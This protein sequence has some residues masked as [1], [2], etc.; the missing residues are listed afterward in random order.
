MELGVSVVGGHTEF[1][2][3]VEHPIVA[4]TMIGVIDSER[5]FSVKNAEV[6]DLIV[7]TKAAGIEAT[8]ILATDLDNEVE[9]IYGRDFVLKAKDYIKNISVVKEASIAAKN[10]GVTA[11]HDCTEGGVIT[12][13][14][15]IAEA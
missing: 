1:T 14:Y 3:S 11:M 13:V 6:G 5:Y 2:S 4:G 15:E 10:P 8:S 9:K 7:E 12:A